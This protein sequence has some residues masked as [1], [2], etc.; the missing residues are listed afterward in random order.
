VPDRGVFHLEVFPHRPHHDLARVDAEADAEGEAVLAPQL[1]PV[2]GQG[3]AQPQRRVA[4]PAG[5]ILVRDRRSEEGHG[6]VAGELV[7][8]PLVAV[9]RLTHDREEAVQERA[10]ELRVNARRQLHRPLHV[11]E[12]HGHLLAL[13]L[14]RPAGQ[15]H[16][17]CQV[18]WKP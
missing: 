6:A 17:L 15:P 1:A 16:L 13:T 9:D 3:V 2:V 5:V 4:G 11:G 18:L 7:H 12:Q 8:R 10:P 14:Q